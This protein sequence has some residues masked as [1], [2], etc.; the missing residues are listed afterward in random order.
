MPTPL[1]PSPFTVRGL[2]R[3]REEHA[4]A[5]M[6]P[7]RSP[8]APSI[9][10]RPRRHVADCAESSSILQLAE[11]SHMRSACSAQRS[12]WPIRWSIRRPNLRRAR[13]SGQKHPPLRRPNAPFR[14]PRQAAPST[15]SPHAV[16]RDRPPPPPATPAATASRRLAAR[17]LKNSA[18]CVALMH[19]RRMLRRHM[20]RHAASFARQRSQPH[21]HRAC[22]IPRFAGQPTRKRL[23][24]RFTDLPA[25]SRCASPAQCQH[26][27]VSA[28]IS[29]RAPPPPVI[30]GSP[31]ASSTTA[32]VALAAHHRH[33]P[34]L[35]GGSNLRAPC[36][37]Q[38]PALPRAHPAHP[39]ELVCS[40]PSA[41]AIC[42]SNTCDPARVSSPH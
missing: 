42:R 37:H 12:F 8:V 32:F 13:P 3:R 35:H 28:V 4:T 39:P 7:A 21:L 34:L 1:A 6:R 31:L 41:G 25:S 20:R 14:P 38:P 15:P 40:S 33:V 26:A 10:H 2:R 29:S 24:A 36:H 27:H 18:T 19:H 22:G 17:R 5:R 23:T 11:L 30:T 16:H 9:T